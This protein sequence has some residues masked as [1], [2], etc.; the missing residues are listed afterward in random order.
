[1]KFIDII[2]KVQE[3]ELLGKF[4]PEMEGFYAGKVGNRYYFVGMNHKSTWNVINDILPNRTELRVF[5]QNRNIFNSNCEEEAKWQSVPY[6][7]SEEYGQHFNGNCY[8]RN[9]DGSGE[10]LI[11]KNKIATF[12]L[13]KI[14]QN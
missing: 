11:Q 12:R 14:L 2:S 3:S 5:Y 9:F 13:I 1:M 4:F 7:T 10:G 6:L 8:C